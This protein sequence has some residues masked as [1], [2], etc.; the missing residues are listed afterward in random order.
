MT[1]IVR[2]IRLH[3]FYIEYNL[4]STYFLVDKNTS[5][6]VIPDDSDEKYSIQD[7]IIN[8]IASKNI[9]QRKKTNYV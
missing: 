6:G 9:F 8:H 7:Q 5:D 1:V 2:I 4:C 3:L